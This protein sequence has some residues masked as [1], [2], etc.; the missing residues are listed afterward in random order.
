MRRLAAALLL[1]ALLSGCAA[2]PPELEGIWTMATVQAE[3]DGAV[4]ACAPGDGALWNGAPERPL[5]LEADDGR[6]TLS[7]RAGQTLTEGTYQPEADGDGAIYR[8]SAADSEGLAVC[9]WT[10]RHGGG[11]RSLTR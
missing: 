3:D 4:V 9:S 10:V 1:T 2:A 5:A 6:F 7:D 11:R 8:L